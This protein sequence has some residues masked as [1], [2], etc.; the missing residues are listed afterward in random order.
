MA[1]DTQEQ[2]KLYEQAAASHGAMI[3]RLARGYE[4]DTDK[5]RDLV[6]DIH[7]ALWRSFAEFAGECALSTWIY[8]VGHNVS[9][10]YV[11]KTKRAN[12]LNSVEDVDII[13][14]DGDLEKEVT[15]DR[16]LRKLQKLIHRLQ[17]PDRQIM[18]LNLEDIPAKDI[19]EITGLSAANISVKIHRIKQVLANNFAEGEPA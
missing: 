7:V 15:Q 8:R 1:H 5:V 4:Y 17:P 10:S 2:D 3:E 16:A 14:D 11:A 6:Q 12:I 13:A 9:A 19:A 18:L